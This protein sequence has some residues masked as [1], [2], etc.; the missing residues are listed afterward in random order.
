MQQKALTAY[1]RNEERA[2]SCWN[3]NRKG[4][5]INFITLTWKNSLLLKLTSVLVKHHA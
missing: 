3:R 1:N 5:G 4:K 2:L